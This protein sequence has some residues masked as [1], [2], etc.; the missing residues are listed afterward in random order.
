[1]HKTVT[2]KMAYDFAVNDRDYSVSLF[3]TFVNFFEFYVTK[4]EFY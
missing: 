1:M 2:G 3:K 4:I